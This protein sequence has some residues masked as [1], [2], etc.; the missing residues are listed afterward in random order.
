M[1]NRGVR[2]RDI[3]FFLWGDRVSE[4]M[5]K[6]LREVYMNPDTLVSAPH[7]ATSAFARISMM[8]DGVN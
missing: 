8:G 4:D 6:G 7:H 5:G 3:L 2:W 1:P